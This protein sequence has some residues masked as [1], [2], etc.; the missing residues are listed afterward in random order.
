MDVR[1]AAAAGITC[2]LRCARSGATVAFPEVVSLYIPSGG[3]LSGN[4][5]G[6]LHL[7]LEFVEHRGVGNW[8]SGVQFAVPFTNPG[9]V[10]DPVP[11]WAYTSGL[12]DA[13]L[14]SNYFAAVGA[15]R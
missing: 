4:A 14:L 10:D 5:N 7:A 9:A 1:A 6:D 2:E 11:G 13:S 8:A 12:R 15:F 3:D